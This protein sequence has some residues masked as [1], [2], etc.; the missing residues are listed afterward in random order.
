[1]I[2]R[3]QLALTNGIKD[4]GLPMYWPTTGLPRG[5]ILSQGQHSLEYDHCGILNVDPTYCSL[6]VLISFCIKEGEYD[7]KII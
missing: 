1:M 7:L 3:Q 6:G 2:H 5:Y 4:F